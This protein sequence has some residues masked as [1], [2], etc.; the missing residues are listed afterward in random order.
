MPSEWDVG[1]FVSLVKVKIGAAHAEAM[2]PAL[3]SI[4]EKFRFCHYH[5]SRALELM[6]PHKKDVKDHFAQA[7]AAMSMLFS[8]SE[9]ERRRFV[10]ALFGARAHSVA[11]AQ[12]LHSTADYLAKVIYR[13]LDLSGQHG[14]SIP[15]HQIGLRKVK[16]KISTVP[17]L[18]SIEQ[19]IGD[20]LASPSSRYLSAF[21]N[22][23]KHHELVDAQ[24]SLSFSVGSVASEGIRMK[25]FQYSG[26]SFGEKWAIDFFEK[27]F[28]TILERTTELGCVLNDYL[29]TK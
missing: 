3:E 22:T 27:D 18:A 11:F 28:Q 17:E 25:A 20:Y 23:E 19:R 5:Y 4:P 10:E 16:E 29:K 15:N 13:G 14:I 9:E 8:Q 24:F 2:L 7:A 1:E 12:C 21:V 6:S 26:D